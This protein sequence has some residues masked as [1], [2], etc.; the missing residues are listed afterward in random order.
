MKQTKIKQN[1]CVSNPAVVVSL[2]EEHFF[3]F[4]RIFV[5]FSVFV[6]TENLVAVR[7]WHVHSRHFLK[8]FQHFCMRFRTLY[9]VHTCVNVFISL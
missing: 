9:D 7:A 4:Q 6:S 2:P 8:K 3:V 5:G 1:V